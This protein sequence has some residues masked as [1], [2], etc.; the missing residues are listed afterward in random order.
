MN[1]LRR[2]NL[3]KSFIGG[4]LEGAV[5]LYAGFPANRFN[6]GF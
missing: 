1:L 3:T 5:Y 6:F 4:N 2:S